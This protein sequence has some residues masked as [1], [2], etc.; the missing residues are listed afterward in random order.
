[1]YTNK[2]NKL[3]SSQK[4]KKTS[5]QILLVQA[6]GISYIDIKLSIVIL[7][8]WFKENQKNAPTIYF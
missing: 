1:M 3:G 7:F 8:W 5:L 6:I 2:F 4:C